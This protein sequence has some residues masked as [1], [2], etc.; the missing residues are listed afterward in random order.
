ME[1]LPSASTTS[2]P[3]FPVPPDRAGLRPI[4]TVTREAGRCSG[5]RPGDHQLLSGR[6]LREQDGKL[7]L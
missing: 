5:T 3:P 2:R 1:F 4:G 7:W 6:V